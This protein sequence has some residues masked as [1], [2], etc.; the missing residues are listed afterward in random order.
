MSILTFAPKWLG[1]RTDIDGVFGFQCV[2]LIK[3]FAK[4]EYGFNPGPWGNAIDYWTNTNHPLLSKFDRVASQSPIEGDIIVFKGTKTNPF[5]HIAIA[6]NSTT[7]LEQNG[8]AGDGDGKGGDEI[9]YRAIPTTSILGILRPKK[10]DIMPD[11]GTLKNVYLDIHGRLPT[12]A[13]LNSFR[14]KS[15]NDPNGIYYNKIQTDI[16]N[17]RADIGAK[18]K[19]IA[20]LE[21]LTSVNRESVLGY[22]DVNL[23]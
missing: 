2:D 11:D 4:D 5:G 7:M 20:E 19:R 14:G 21:K 8:A 6:V 13:E 3:Q 12:E 22:L 9:R 15:M 1:K 18:A 10:G 23:K 17:L 16:R